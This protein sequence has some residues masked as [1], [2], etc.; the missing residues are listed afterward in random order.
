MK[1]ISEFKKGTTLERVTKRGLFSEEYFRIKKFEF[2]KGLEFSPILRGGG[3][4]RGSRE[5]G[6]RQDAKKKE[7]GC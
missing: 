5:G 1:A 6:R 7:A 3:A 4:D 2:F